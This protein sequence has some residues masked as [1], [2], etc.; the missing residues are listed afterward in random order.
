M[1][2]ISETTET[3][4]ITNKIFLEAHKNIINFSVHEISKN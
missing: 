4:I 2:V 1:S 3:N